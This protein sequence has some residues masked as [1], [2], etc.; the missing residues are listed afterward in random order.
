M[1]MVARNK[2][3]RVCEVFFSASYKFSFSCRK[4]GRRIEEKKIFIFKSIQ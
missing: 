3:K 2:N 4:E 1:K